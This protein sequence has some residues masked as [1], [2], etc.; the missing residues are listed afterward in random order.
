ML[1]SGMLRLL[2]VGY[3][4]HTMGDPDFRSV[5]HEAND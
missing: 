3:R 2:L 4:E 5:S 1:L